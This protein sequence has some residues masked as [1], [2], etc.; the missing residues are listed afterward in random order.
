MSIITK[1]E[2][3]LHRRVVKYAETNDGYAFV[4]EGFGSEHG[5]NQC[6]QDRVFLSDRCGNIK[7]AHLTYPL[8]TVDFIDRPMP[9]ITKD[10]LINI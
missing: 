7:I 10:D 2:N 5:I 9:E 1:L 8:E 6:F 3:D 4:I